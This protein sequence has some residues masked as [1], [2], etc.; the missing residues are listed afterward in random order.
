VNDGLNILDLSLSVNGKFVSAS[1]D[2]SSINSSA[3]GV[4]S[5]G[6]FGVGFTGGVVFTDQEIELAVHHHGITLTVLVNVDMFHAT[7]VAV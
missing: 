1:G 2:S 7:S 5:T 3:V 4:V 6:L